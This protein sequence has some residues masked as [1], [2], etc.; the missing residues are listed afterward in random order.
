MRSLVEKFLHQENIVFK[1]VIELPN[2]ESIKRA[3]EEQLGISLI[4][5]V[6]IQY[7]L[8]AGRL[9]EIP[10]NRLNNLDRSFL[11]ISRGDQEFNPAETAFIELL[12][13]L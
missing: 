5:S 1:S 13:E 2:H 8:K 4:S 12:E 9:V 11:L 7:E 10:L 6:A 3:V